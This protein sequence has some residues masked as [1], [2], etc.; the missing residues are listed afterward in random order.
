MDEQIQNII[1]NG[2]RIVVEEEPVHGGFRPLVVL[3]HL[4]EDVVTERIG[5]PKDA[6]SPSWRSGAWINYT[7][8][9][10]EYQIIEI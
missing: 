6:N 4:G 2:Q 9:E 8:N 3:Y 10:Q 1:E 7:L 5:Y